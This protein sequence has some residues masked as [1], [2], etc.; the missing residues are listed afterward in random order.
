MKSYEWWRRQKRRVQKK[1]TL[2]MGRY[3]S[4][5]ESK[6]WLK[7]WHKLLREEERRML[8]K[9]KEAAE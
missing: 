5:K 9:K 7:K 8:K 2:L 4:P 1:Y 6:E 3:L